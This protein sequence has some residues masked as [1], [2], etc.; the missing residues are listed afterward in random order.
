MQ[1]RA[2]PAPNLSP[3]SAL[4]GGCFCGRPWDPAPGGVGREGVL[5]GGVGLDTEA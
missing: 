2:R 3:D 1:W 4:G 5:V